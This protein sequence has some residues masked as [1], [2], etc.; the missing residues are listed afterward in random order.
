[1]AQAAASRKTPSWQTWLIRAALVAVTIGVFSPLFKAQ[2]L[3]WDDGENLFDNPRMLPPSWANCGYYWRHEYLSL[4][5][6]MTYTV[7]SALAAVA[8]E[9]GDGPNHRTLNPAIFHGAN[10]AVH[11]LAVVVIFNIL[12]LLVADLPA[13]AG[14]LLFAIHP[15]QAEAV[16]WACGMKDL[17]AG[18]FGFVA[19]WQYILL[20]GR[21][22]R[23]LSPRYALATIAFALALL[24]KP[25]AAATPLIA[26]ALAY[27]LMH[28]P[29][30]QVVAEIGPWL[31]LSV[32][33]AV[34]AVL[35]QPAS[36]QL[37]AVPIWARPLIAADA[38]AFYL[39]KLAWPVRLCL[40]YGRTPREILSVVPYY[41]YWTWIF[42]AGFL[43]VLWW[44]RRRWPRVFAAAIIFVAGLLP[45]LGLIRFNFQGISTVTDHYLYPAMLA[46]ALALASLLNARRHSLGVVAA[47]AGGLAVLALLCHAQ[48][49]KWLNEPA[50]FGHATDINPR[51]WIGHHHLWQW[52]MDHGNAP[53]AETQ[54]RG[55]IAGNPNNVNGYVDLADSLAA[56]DRWQAAADAYEQ[57]IRITPDDPVLYNNLASL[58]GSHG[59]PLRAI[60]LYRKALELNPD[61]ADA[62]TGLATALRAAGNQK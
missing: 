56:M 26:G 13:M 36:Y 54:A 46:P 9:P 18:L 6:P 41:A 29:F 58:Y 20:C 25:S 33:M 52:D 1:M 57:A 42:P 60:P 39:Y 3:Q 61:Y 53:L 48:T 31:M 2:F 30:R 22:Q 4:Y 44:K 17:L 34:V 11:A 14:A 55:V 21:N 5:I 59:R 40:D 51:S 16:G 32:V 15:V 50:A 62:R 8:Q 38:L 47:V 37:L 28:R 43:V 24:S 23:M 12:R 45:V 27:L 35:V 10:I 49:F 19:I 7:W